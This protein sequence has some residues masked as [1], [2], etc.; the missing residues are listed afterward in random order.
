MKA[1]AAVADVV[2]TAEMAAEEDAVDLAVTAMIVVVDTVVTV[3][4]VVANHAVAVA[5]DV[6]MEVETAQVAAAM[7]VVAKVA[8]SEEVAVAKNHHRQVAEDGLA[9]RKALTDQLALVHL[10]VKKQ[11]LHLEKNHNYK[12]YSQ[13]KKATQMSGFFIIRKM[14]SKLIT[15]NELCLLLPYS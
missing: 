6:A 2:V 12:M 5:A 10:L 1:A 8:D 7:T 14:S 11:A 13:N 9:Q 3:M 15:H 4:T